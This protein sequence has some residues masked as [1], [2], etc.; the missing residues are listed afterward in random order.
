MVYAPEREWSA[1][2]IDEMSV[3]PKGRYD[4]L[5]DSATQAINYLRRVGLAHTDDEVIFDEMESIRHRPKP[6]ALYPV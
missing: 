3:F 2:V 4:D 5:T 1:M 6:K